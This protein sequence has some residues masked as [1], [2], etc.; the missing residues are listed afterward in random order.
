MRWADLGPT[1]GRQR[2]DSI[3]F[4]RLVGGV[5]MA[6]KKIPEMENRTCFLKEAWSL[7]PHASGSAGIYLKTSDVSE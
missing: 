5:T 3:R 1:P 7:Q 6:E 2:N 4:S